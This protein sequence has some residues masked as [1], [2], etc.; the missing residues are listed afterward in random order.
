MWPA[1]WSIDRF[2]IYYSDTNL[3]LIDYACCKLCNM[4][5]FLFGN[6]SR[7]YPYKGASY[8]K[9]KIV[10]FIT[11]ERVIDGNLKR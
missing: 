5:L 6:N 4:L 7:S 10:A 9:R 2:S 3:L 8:W 1:S 11:Q